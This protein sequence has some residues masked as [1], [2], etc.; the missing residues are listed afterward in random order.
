[1]SRWARMLIQVNE[2]NQRTASEISELFENSWAVVTHRYR[3]ALV[4][5]IHVVTQCKI[6]YGSTK[7]THVFLSSACCIQNNS[8]FLFFRSTSFSLYLSVVQAT[9]N[10]YSDRSLRRRKN[11][12]MRIK[13]LN[14]FFFWIP[15]VNITDRFLS[16]R[17]LQRDWPFITRGYVS[18]EARV[19]TICALT[20]YNS[21]ELTY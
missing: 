2:I 6:S 12:L 19:T 20:K 17:E 15:F 18:F 13:L 21:S 4:Y 3:R 16:F 9:M 11:E 14:I 7:V 5:R 8:W 10:V 1:M